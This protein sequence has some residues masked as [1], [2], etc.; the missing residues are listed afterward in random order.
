[1]KTAEKNTR[2]GVVV[3]VA[4]LAIVLGILCA[5]AERSIFANWDKRV[6]CEI[7]GCHALHEY[8][9]QFAD[10]VH[11]LCHTHYAYG[12]V[13]DTGTIKDMNLLWVP[14]EWIKDEK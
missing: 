4:V 13:L 2:C 5:T 3:I 12:L 9:V 11:A 10:G 7:K 1:M 14:D 8:R 6:R